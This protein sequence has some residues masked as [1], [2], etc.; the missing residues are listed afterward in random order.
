[1]SSSIDDQLLL[2]STDVP[3]RWRVDRELSGRVFDEDVIEGS[4]EAWLRRLKSAGRLFGTTRAWVGWSPKGAWA[5]TEVVTVFSTPAGAADVLADDEN[6]IDADR[7]WRRVPLPT[8]PGGGSRLYR[9]ALAPERPG[10]EE[11]V[12]WLIRW[13]QATMNVSVLVLAAPGSESLGFAIDV[14]ARAAARLEKV[15]GRGRSATG[16]SAPLVASIRRR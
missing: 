11:S 16:P 1:M 2:R 3:G 9:R 14:A 15:I 5:V 7:A 6:P 8:S 13:R 10:G 4:S 12:M